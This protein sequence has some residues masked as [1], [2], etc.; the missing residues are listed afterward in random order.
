MAN[1]F[2]NALTEETN[3]SHTLNGG[4]AYKSTLNK[5]M[6]MFALGGAFRGRNDDDC[7]L[8]FKNAYEEDSTLALKCLFYLRDCREGAGERRFFRV[9][10]RWL[11]V[12]HPEAASRNLRN[13]AEYGRFDDL[14]YS[15]L[16]T[17]IQ[18]DALI[19]IKEQLIKDL[20]SDT[21]S[22]LA[23]W[24]P[25][26]NCSSKATKRAANIVRNWLQ[27]SNK[28]YRQTLSKLRKQINV[29]ECLMSVNEWDKIDFSKIPSRA[30]LI[31]KD[32]FARRDLIA[33]KYE[34]FAKDANTKVNAGTLYPYEIVSKVGKA[35]QYWENASH[36]AP[37]DRA[38]VNKYWENLPDYLCGNPCKIMC[39]VDTSGSM[40]IR[41]K[42]GVPIDV[43]I[44]LGMYC[45]ERIGGP[46]KD[47]YISFAS[48]PKFI[49][50]E[51]VD[52]ADKVCR[53]VRTNLCDN[54]NL[55]A[56]FDMLLDVALRSDVNINDLPE[57]L[58]IISDMEIDE[59]TYSYSTSQKHGWSINSA[60]TEMDKIREKWQEHDLKLPKLV[61]WNVDA[62]Q[63]TILDK[64]SDVTFV[65]GLSPILFQSI[66]SGKSGWD[67]C[68]DKLLSER[69]NP[70]Y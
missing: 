59:A 53:I 56:V 65:S 39:V 14:L 68:L 18:N 60:Q 25:S 62:K 4:T 70:V 8:L 24:L 27:M 13:I 42:Y 10:F 45:A 64:G 21:P 1:T 61:Y 35:C 52:F 69:Y 22:L 66:L 3:Y 43:A 16:D 23:K 57:T 46:F 67:L 40:T 6:D 15:T 41:R 54:T 34:E 9:C 20:N 58:I 5:V 38:M 48:K 28:E 31:Y 29:L 50:V 30:G 55:E 7:I 33:K 63:N 2:M 19:I 51:G 11:A 37:V 49:K 17:P 32:A 12:N 26:L 36:M 44:S 47:H